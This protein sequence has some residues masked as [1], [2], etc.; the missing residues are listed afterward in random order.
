MLKAHAFAPT[1]NPLPLPTRSRWVSYLL[2]WLASLL[3][4][5]C[6]GGGGGGGGEPGPG[7]GGAPVISSAPA[8]VAV[9]AG[10]G[11]TFSVSVTGSAP[12]TFE[13]L[14]NGV[15]IAGSNS[16]SYSIA[17]TVL[18]DSG[19]QFSVRVSNAVG[20]VQS[21]PATLTVSPAPV[22][23]SITAQPASVSTTVGQTATF[24]AAATGSGTLAYQ[25][26]RDGNAIA[27]ATAASYTTAVLGLA[28]NGARFDVV[29]S[30]SVGS[31]ASSAALLT[32]NPLPV[33]PSIATQPASQTVT[34][35]DRA[36]FAVVANGD[37]VLSYQW[38]RNGQDIAG[39][40]GAQ[41][42]TPPVTLADSGATFTV[43]VR[44]GA[45]MVSSAAVTLTVN[46][47]P[48][49]PS[50]SS[51]PQAASLVEGSSASFSVTASGSGT[52]AYQWRRNGVNIAGANQ[53][54]YNTPA[55]TLADNGARY[56]VVVSNAVGSITSESALLTVNAAPVAAA[57]T[58][59][60]QAQTVIIGQLAS[61]SVTATGTGPLGYQWRRNSV[62][63]EGATQPSYV[64]P[65]TSLADN[66]ARYSVVVSNQLGSVTSAE[67][68]LTVQPPVAANYWLRGNAGVSR[69]G[70]L[71]FASG[72]QAATEYNLTLVNPADLAAPV[73]AEARGGWLPITAAGEPRFNPQNPGDSS[74][75]FLVYARGSHL[76][77]LDL[78]IPSDPANPANPITP[79]VIPTPAQLGDVTLP[80]L[81]APLTA[82]IVNLFQDNADAG[83]SVLQFRQPGADN[84]CNTADDSFVALRVSAASTAAPV[85]VPRLLSAIYSASGAI[86]G[87]VGRQ[88]NQILRLNAEL[89]DATELF[90]VGGNVL[91]LLR[92]P[93]GPGQ[94][95]FRDGSQLR[96][97]DPATNT[98]PVNFG[99]AAGDFLQ[100]GEVGGGT[101]TALYRN[102]GR[103]V[104]YR[105]DNSAPL[106][107][108]V[109]L[110]AGQ[111]V[112]RGGGDGQQALLVVSGAGVSRLLR[113][114]S[115]GTVSTVTDETG[116]IDAGSVGATPTRYIYTT[117][118]GRTLRSVLRE[119]G[120]ALTLAS[121]PR[122]R[123]FSQGSW[124]YETVWYELRGQGDVI[125]GSEL[126]VVQSDGSNAQVLANAITVGGALANGFG[127]TSVGRVVAQPL[128]ANAAAPFSA[129]RLLALDPVTRAVRVDYGALAAGSYNSVDVSRL[130]G[131]DRPVLVSAA[132][133][134][135][136]GVSSV[137]LY[138][139]RVG[140]PGMTRLTA[141]VP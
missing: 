117:G 41:Y 27:G 129:A 57:V 103:I 34:E 42:A 121:S 115:N 135:L 84:Q 81:C 100:L 73:V 61:F 86:T 91:E 12:F 3:L 21:T 136:P 82:G 78:L 128:A 92:V 35:G 58:V 80:A 105:L 139:L 52:L 70:T 107:T 116:V 90:S 16:A 120:A 44:N 133:L 54:S 94:L 75:R 119:G 25:W 122:L 106:Q 32:V 66:G 55:L 33:P 137:D 71:A 9:T 87:F 56:D 2:A 36:Q 37:P 40:T 48:V 31:V 97:V 69:A 15:P 53:A 67:A 29:V 104:S 20:S 5:A 72:D 30:N 28:D 132:S 39:A 98:P 110:A 7:P 22:A 130:S 49:A 76:W 127:D 45:G 4:L 96:A 8:N 111:T 99:T 85:V 18:A 1:L 13:W 114:D 43:E 109:N 26:R 118:G 141:F 63:I 17:A 14:R 24:S 64:T 108:L 38:R 89:A 140:T 102:D 126:R 134:Q 59:P 131:P 138:F 79:V 23:P 6:G 125:A 62:A 123:V 60:P 124:D 95:V 47:L 46:P 83:R 101:P 112:T 93:A 19:A 77:R 51:P 113:V 11:A 74:E 88:G 65:V 68:V 50:I 10:Q